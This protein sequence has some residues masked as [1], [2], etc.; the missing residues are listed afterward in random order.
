MRFFLKCLGSWI[1]AVGVSS[2]LIG[3][4]AGRLQFVL[5]APILCVPLLAIIPLIQLPVTRLLVKRLQGPSIRRLV[6]VIVGVVSALPTIFG[7][8]V[9]LFYVRGSKQ[10]QLSH[11]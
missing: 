1:V 11:G 7:G 9:G 5:G 2:L 8:L 10:N 3:A 4:N 6:S